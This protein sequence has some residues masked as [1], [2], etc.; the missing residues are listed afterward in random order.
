MTLKTLILTLSASF[1]C[2]SCNNKDDDLYM[3][4]ANTDLK[5]ELKFCVDSL[6]SIHQGQDYAIRVYCQNINDSIRRF[7]VSTEIDYDIWYH[8]PYHFK[9]KVG[10]KDILFVMLAGQETDRG[11]EKPFFTLDSTRYS[12]VVKKYFPKIYKKYG[13]Q[14]YRNPEV[15]YEPPLIHLTFL[16]GKLIGKCHEMGMPSDRVP[17]NI[18]GK[19]VYL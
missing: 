6:N 12:N 15:I 14:N 11:F 16:N 10:G 5:E 2:F 19:T 17:V 3:E 1:L 9:S 7:T 8:C 4:I 18:G 13:L